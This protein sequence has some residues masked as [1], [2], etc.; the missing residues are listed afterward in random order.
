MIPC[1]LQFK[2][3]SHVR[4]EDLPTRF[5]DLAVGIG[6]LRTVENWA[7]FL[8]NGPLLGVPQPGFATIGPL[9]PISVFA[10]HRSKIQRR[11]RGGYCTGSQV[12]SS[13][14]PL[15]T[16]LMTCRLLLLVCGIILSVSS[17]FAVPVE[18]DSVLTVE[19]DSVLTVF[20]QVSIAGA[21]N[22]AEEAGS[23]AEAGERW[24]CKCSCRDKSCYARCRSCRSTPTPTPVQ[25]IS[26]TK[27][28]PGRV[29]Q[30]T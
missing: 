26:P 24:W 21:A 8:T 18:D 2:I 5:S 10:Q 3:A 25:I 1:R 9:L 17:T 15:D 14:V 22:A 6:W 13:S 20:N 19:D 11:Q 29:N 30:Q 16:V 27:P 12:D 4:T 23:D 28:K 7:V